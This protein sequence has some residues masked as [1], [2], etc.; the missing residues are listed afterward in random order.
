[1]LRDWSRF[2]RIHLCSLKQTAGEYNVPQIDGD[3]FEQI[4]SAIHSTNSDSSDPQRVSIAGAMRGVLEGE[5]IPTAAEELLKIHK[6]WDTRLF[7]KSWFFLDLMVMR[8]TWEVSSIPSYLDQGHSGSRIMA[9]NPVVD[10]VR[11]SWEG[12]TLSQ[13]AV[14]CRARNQSIDFYYYCCTIR[15]QK[16]IAKKQDVV[17][18]TQRGTFSSAG[19]TLYR[20]ISSSPPGIHVT[21]DNAPPKRRASFDSLCFPPMRLISSVR[22]ANYPVCNYN[23]RIHSSVRHADI[24][25]RVIGWR[26]EGTIAEHHLWWIGQRNHRKKYTRRRYWR[27]MRLLS[28]K[29]IPAEHPSMT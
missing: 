22:R 9:K 10:I 4:A 18:S 19:L 23:M 6:A 21:I 8:R 25:E 3:C 20:Q 15:W 12:R 11:W 28:P 26:W 24:H 29:G 7:I 17:L 2:N 13:N 5:Q 27:G 14:L 1:M 16:S